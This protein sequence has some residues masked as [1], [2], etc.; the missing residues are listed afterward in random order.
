[1]ANDYAID[2]LVDD[3]W[4][5][6]PELTNIFDYN[7]KVLGVYSTGAYEGDKF[8]LKLGLR[9][10]NTDL[11]T[12]LVNTDETN[13]QQFTNLFPTAHTSY[14]VRDNFSMQAG[15][16]RRISRPRMW[17]LNPFFNIRNT[18]S[19]RTGNPE[20]MPE[21]TDSYEVTGIYD[22]G[23]FSLNAA[24]Y[25]RYTTDVVEEVSTFED[26]VSITKPMNIGINRATGLEV[27]AKYYATDWW[28]LN[29]D[30]NYNYF[31]REGNYEATSF[32]FNSD[33]WTA[34]M[35]TKFKLPAEIDFEVTGSYRSGYQTFQQEISGYMFADL[36][37]RK[38]LM[39]GKT[40][41]NLSIRDVFASQI[42]ESETVQ[43]SFYLY[44]YR[45][46][47]RFVTFGISY[48]F[49]KGEAME[50]SGQKRF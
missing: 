9:V 26:N 33:Q 47:G 17:D 27:N 14:K 39:K 29:G 21:Y 7:Q 23:P 2:N 31:N 41:L 38:K 18:F 6:V 34:R 8:G 30:F 45:M 32:D 37:V 43:P 12:V 24:V 4:V 13:K 22:Q 25:Y 3:E 1:V 49:G 46:R 10:E 11:S 50:F 16:S 42:F 44:D 19:I 35:T 20:L 28:T 40:I 5:N 15:Y 48:G 36:G